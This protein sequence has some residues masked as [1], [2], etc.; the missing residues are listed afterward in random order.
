MLV[1]LAIGILSLCLVLFDL[2]SQ[3]FPS[4]GLWVK[5]YLIVASMVLFGYADHRI[6]HWQAEEYRLFA[7]FG[8]NDLWEDMWKHRQWV[9]FWTPQVNTHIH[10]TP[11]W[12]KQEKI[13]FAKRYG[14]SPE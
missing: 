14:F 4:I 9:Q 8:I 2:Y 13:N 5:F 1:F 6:K 7:D 12:L 11:V 3:T 10:R